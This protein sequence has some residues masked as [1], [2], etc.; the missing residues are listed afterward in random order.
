MKILHAIL[1]DTFYG[2]ER[3][4][5]ELAA[6]QAATGHEVR[7]LIA[8]A[9]PGYQN[10]FIAPGVD[11]VELPVWLPTIL[12][13]PYARRL[14]SNFRADIV[15]THLEP[16]ARRVGA[17]AERLSVP[18]IATLHLDY[19]HRE[20]RNCDGLI[21]IASWQRGSIPENHAG[22]IEVVHNW[23]P[24]RV[25]Q[26]IAGADA[27]TAQRLRQDWGAGETTTVF[28]SVGRLL[29][30]KGMDVLVGAFLDAFPN[31]GE[32]VRLVIVGDGAQRAVLEAQAVAETRIVLAG[33]RD[34][35]APFY[36]AFDT[37]V[38]AARF[39]P[40]G[41]TILEAMA[42]GCRLVLT[43]TQGPPEFVMDPRVQ[44]CPVG[45]PAALAQVMRAEVGQGRN[46]P[47]YDMAPFAPAVAA[48]A[49]E[50]LYRTVIARRTAVRSVE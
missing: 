11:L 28:G 19:S 16:A 3:Y 46:R 41:L 18:H 39:E 15:H 50:A 34:D 29:P 9:L 30:E 33:W 21:C 10:N 45:D 7:I 40:F 6:L 4:C 44:W 48:Q 8:A 32:D 5:V 38:S 27:A 43:R 1:T 47:V 35:V 31:G 14:I 13:R 22:H 17:V 37:Y 12:H 42:A 36:G 23:L 2:S 25:A 49:I 24:G 26:D 20:H